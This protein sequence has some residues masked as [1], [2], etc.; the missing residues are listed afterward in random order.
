[1]RSL[2]SVVIKK[3]TDLSDVSESS[4]ALNAMQVAL[5]KIALIQ[6][7]EFSK[8]LILDKIFSG[9]QQLTLMTLI[10]FLLFF[11]SYFTSFI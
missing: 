8:S 7:Q 10:G 1:M 2:K 6:K 4:L 3:E 5:L 9:H 11:M